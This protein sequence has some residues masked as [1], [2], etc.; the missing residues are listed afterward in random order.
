MP[1]FSLALCWLLQMTALD[2]S[3]TVVCISHP[4]LWSLFRSPPSHLDGT[5]V[6][7]EVLLE[8]KEV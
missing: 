2:R 1:F 3:E 7:K 8:G 4:R 5:R 6:R